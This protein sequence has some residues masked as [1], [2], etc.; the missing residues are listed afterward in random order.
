[1]SAVQT[2]ARCMSNRM[3]IG[4]RQLNLTAWRAAWRRKRR[5]QRRPRRRRRR[6]SSSSLLSNDAVDTRVERSVAKAG[7]AEDRSAQMLVW[8]A[9]PALVDDRGRRRDRSSS[10]TAGCRIR[11][12]HR[13]SGMC[14]KP[15]FGKARILDAGRSAGGDAPR[16]TRRRPRSSTTNKT[17]RL[18]VGFVFVRTTFPSWLRPPTHRS[19]RQGF[20]G[21]GP[22]IKSAAGFFAIVRFQRES[23]RP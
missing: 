17:P 16:V 11:P 23:V 1:M 15:R 12:T 14:V 2:T 5:R 4:R 10:F 6:R 7:E 20:V 21:A 22:R 3:C 13:R 9:S 18:G 19:T 8:V